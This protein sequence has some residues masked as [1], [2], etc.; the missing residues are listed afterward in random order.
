M[1]PTQD[2]YGHGTME[3]T[4]ENG[5]NNNRDVNWNEIGWEI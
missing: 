1:I 4:I 2:V 5:N 3:K